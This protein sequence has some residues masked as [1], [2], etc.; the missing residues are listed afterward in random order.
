RSP[1]IRLKNVVFPAPFGPMMP[2][3]SP[4]ATRRFML[5][6][7]RTAPYDLV[8]PVISMCSMGTPDALFQSSVF[9]FLEGTAG[10]DIRSCLV[11]G[12]DELIGMWAVWRAPPLASDER[13]LGDV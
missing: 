1:E 11:V 6:A 13:G 2:I 8:R 9:Q 10:R 4:R 3:A 5:S 12:Y 7:T